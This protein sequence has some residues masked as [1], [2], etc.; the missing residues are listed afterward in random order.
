MGAKVFVVV[1]IVLSGMMGSFW[2]GT[3]LKRTCEPK[4]EMLQERVDVMRLNRTPAKNGEKENDSGYE[5]DEVLVVF[6]GD[7]STDKARLPNL[8]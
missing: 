8:S 6:D 5:S 1:L 3:T 4:K 2:A 7:E